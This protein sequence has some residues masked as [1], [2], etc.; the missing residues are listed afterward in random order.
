METVAI[1]ILGL[2][3]LVAYVIGARSF[4]EPQQPEFTEYDLPEMPAKAVK[5]ANVAKSAKAAEAEGSEFVGNQDG[6]ILRGIFFSDYHHPL[7]HLPVEVIYTFI[8]EQKPDV[9]IFGGDMGNGVQDIQ[10]SYFITGR[11]AAYCQ[12][13]GIPFVAIRG[14]HDDGLDPAEAAQYGYSLLVNE[15]YNVKAQDGSWWQLLGLEDIRL[16]KGDPG[17]ALAARSARSPELPEG[18]SEIPSARRILLAHNPDQILSLE[19]TSGAFCLSGHFHGGQIRLPFH[20]EFS[21]LRSEIL[22]RLGFTAGVYQIHGITHFI[23]RGYGNVLFP[24]RL[25]VRPEISCLTFHETD[26]VDSGENDRR[27]AAY[28][29]ENQLT[30]LT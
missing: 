9:V 12:D 15:H 2:V 26:P 10:G 14:N 19:R 28:I 22:C 16:G 23:S 29:Q 7:N 25:G 27:I 8:E 13:K 18:Q 30:P 24:N 4:I 11:I 3:L 21:M 17:A 5:A 6:S 1:I 20:A